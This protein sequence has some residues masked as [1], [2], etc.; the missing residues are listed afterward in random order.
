MYSKIFLLLGKEFYMKKG[1][2]FIMVLA[3]SSTLVVSAAESQIQNFVNKKIAPLTQ[4]EQE[5]NAKM[6]AQRK[7]SEARRLEQEKKAAEQ[8]K[9]I[10]A[11]KTELQKQLDANKKAVADAQK[12][13]Q[14]RQEA[15]KKEFEAQKSYWKSLFG[16]Q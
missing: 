6:E 10:E 3:I 1:L 16:Q 5:F 9:A 13:A 14:A 2:L 4:K 8:Q 15:R 11:K 12:E 7:A